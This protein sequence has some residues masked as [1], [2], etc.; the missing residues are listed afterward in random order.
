MSYVGPISCPT[1]HS[2]LDDDCLCCPYCQS[3]VPASAPWHHGHSWAP[4]IAV[5]LVLLIGVACDRLCGTS[6]LATIA[7]WLS[8]NQ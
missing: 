2:P 3:W 8:G 6:I 5:G 7:D 1:C 4:W